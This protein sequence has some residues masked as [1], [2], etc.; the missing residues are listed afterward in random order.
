MWC[1][2]GHSSGT[3]EDGETARRPQR[4]AWLTPG[5]QWGV[6]ESARDQLD[7]ANSGR[8]SESG[9]DGSERAGVSLNRDVLMLTKSGRRDRPDSSGRPV[10]PGCPDFPGRPD[11]SGHPIFRDVRKFPGRPD[12]SGTSGFFCVPTSV[13][14]DGTLLFVVGD[15]SG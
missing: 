10:F 14:R 15:N 9:S 2:T 11:Y 3:P 8:Q 13:F 5:G 7:L 1:G 6:P 4:T 12:V